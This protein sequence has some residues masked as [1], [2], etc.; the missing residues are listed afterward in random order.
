MKRDKENAVLGG[1]CAG[2]A[3]ALD[4]P[5]VVVRILWLASIIWL[6]IPLLLYPL[7]WLLMP[8]E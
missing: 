3:K 8:E 4:M 7:F 6:G 5:V 1:V 2:M